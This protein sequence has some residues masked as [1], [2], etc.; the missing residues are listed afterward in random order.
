MGL[1]LVGGCPRCNPHSTTAAPDLALQER[2]CNN[3]QPT[4]KILDSTR[5]VGAYGYARLRA[6]C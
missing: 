2:R 3:R 5:F 6:S 4:L 1:L